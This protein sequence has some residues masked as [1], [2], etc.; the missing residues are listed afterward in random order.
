MGPIADL[1]LKAKVETVAWLSR[2]GKVVFFTF[3]A[4][5]KQNGNQVQLYLVVTL[6]LV[7]AS[8]NKRHD[9]PELSFDV[10]ATI[11]AFSNTICR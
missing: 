7:S 8:R 6:L 3:S 2:F 5:V 9:L 10:I 11:I 1:W 4:T